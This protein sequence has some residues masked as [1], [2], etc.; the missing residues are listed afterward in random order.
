MSRFIEEGLFVGYNAKLDNNK[1]IVSDANY[2]RTHLLRK[3]VF[4]VLSV[5]S[6]IW[7]SIF[8]TRDDD[9]DHIRPDHVGS[10]QKLW[11]DMSSLVKKTPYTSEW[12]IVAVKLVMSNRSTGYLADWKEQLAVVEAADDSCSWELMGYDVA[13]K[14]LTSS[15]CNCGW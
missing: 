1:A 8:D 3:D 11:S 2:C 4:D 5:D 12:A 7:P 15:L 10:V 6:A 14:Y 13:D 9:P